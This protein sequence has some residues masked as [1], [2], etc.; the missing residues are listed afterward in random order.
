MEEKRKTSGKRGIIKK[1]FICKRG[2]KKGRMIEKVQR[3]SK[4]K[5]VTRKWEKKP[6]R[7]IFDR[8]NL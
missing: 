2:K 1:D 7:E 8:K 4:S 3:G 6:E 5:R